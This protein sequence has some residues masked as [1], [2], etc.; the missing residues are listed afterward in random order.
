MKIFP[1]LV[2]LIFPLWSTGDIC[3]V[4]GYVTTQ[5]NMSTGDVQGGTPNC[6]P[7]FLPTHFMSWPCYGFCTGILCRRPHYLL[8]LQYICECA[9]AWVS[10]PSGL[11]RPFTSTVLEQKEIICT[12]INPHFLYQDSSILPLF[13]FKF[14]H[15]VCHLSSAQIRN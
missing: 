8:T 5:Q 9:H 2:P 4:H 10:E 12:L 6:Q 3:Y 11:N 7:H 15:L 1:D 13:S 14:G